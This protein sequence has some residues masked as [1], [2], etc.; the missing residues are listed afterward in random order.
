MGVAKAAFKEQG[1]WQ[2]VNGDWV[3]PNSEWAKAMVKGRRD[4]C[5]FLDGVVTYLVV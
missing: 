4:E 3:R 1:Q 5:G 2:I